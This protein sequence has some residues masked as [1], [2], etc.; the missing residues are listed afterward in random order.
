MPSPEHFGHDLL[1]D[2]RA[3][4]SRHEHDPRRAF[5]FRLASHYYG[6]TSGQGLT[7]ESVGALPDVR[8]TR[9]RVRQI[10]DSGVQCLRGLEKPLS[11]ATTVRHA[12]DLDPRPYARAA[13]WFHQLSRER[14]SMFVALQDLLTQPYFASFADNHK[15]AIALLNDAGI[16]QVMYRNQHYLYPEGHPRKEAIGAVQAANKRLR[17]QRTLRKMLD[18]SKT[19]TWVPVPTRSALKTIADAHD[20]GLNRLYE[21]ILVAFQN[22]APYRAQAGLTAGATVG[23]PRRPK[24]GTAE[25]AGAWECFAKTTA[26]RSRNGKATE[27]QVGI[28][29]KKSIADQAKREARHNGTSFMSY[30]RCAFV[31]F[32]N[33]LTPDHQATIARQDPLLASDA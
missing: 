33:D 30:I 13:A 23:K 29:I 4:W 16:R 3:A 5:A 20:V 26:W 2:L 22:A 28:Y 32:V 24:A 1:Q 7:L 14:K 11:R 31:W 6:I 27:A 8:L 19:V 9:E 17:H 15:G 18:M 25:A 21:R 12:E 10:I